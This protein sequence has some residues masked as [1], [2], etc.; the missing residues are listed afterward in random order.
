MTERQN[1]KLEKQ[2]NAISGM[3]IDGTSAAVEYIFFLHA[4]KPKDIKPMESKKMKNAQKA[5]E[6]MRANGGK[7][8]RD[9]S[10]RTL[11]IMEVIVAAD[12]IMD[13]RDGIQY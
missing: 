4:K 3:K 5:I 12:E 2:L 1:T 6:K 13:E 8:Y 10:D 9:L 7:Q 11:K